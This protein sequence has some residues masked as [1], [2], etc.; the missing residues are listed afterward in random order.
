MRT[1]SC[2]IFGSVIS[3]TWE[4]TMFAIFLLLDA[5][6]HAAGSARRRG[7]LMSAPG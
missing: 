6:V 2:L 5:P 4:A 1:A 3:V 7:S